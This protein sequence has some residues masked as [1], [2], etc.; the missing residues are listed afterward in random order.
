M[1]V[2]SIL[3]HVLSIFGN[4]LFMILGLIAQAA[5]VGLCIFFSRVDWVKS[6]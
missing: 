5:F 3:R 1:K 2:L 4:I 6:N